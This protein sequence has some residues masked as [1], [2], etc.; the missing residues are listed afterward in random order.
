M[1]EERK[2]DASIRALL[3]AAA[4]S[5]CVVL[6]ASRVDS[7]AMTLT[8]TWT[9]GG[10]THTVTTHQQPDESYDDFAARHQAAVAAQQAEYPP[11]K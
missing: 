4:V 6:G 3:I 7:P 11:D 2:G 8:T 5:A 10:V 9:S 1:I